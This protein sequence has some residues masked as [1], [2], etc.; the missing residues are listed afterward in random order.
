M[1]WKGGVTK[2]LIC[3][4]C[5]VKFDADRSDKKF[6][7]KACYTNYQKGKPMMANVMGKRGTKPRTYYLKARP[8]HEG[9]EYQE[10]RMAVW[11]RDNFVCQDCK[12]TSNELK[13]IKVKICAD[14]IKPFCNYPKLRYEVSNGRTLCIPC[15]KL[16]PTYGSR[17]RY[18]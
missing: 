12:R 10:W 5:G 1:S 17:A 3:K 14:H 18:F 15:H 7:T 4:G 6:C 11:K 2:N 16:T 8:K 9:V 13:K